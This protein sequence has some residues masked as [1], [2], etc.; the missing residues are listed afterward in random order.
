M[1]VPSW[2]AFVQDYDPSLSVSAGVEGGEG[3]QGQKSMHIALMLCPSI[4]LPHM[5][6]INRFNNSERLVLLCPLSRWGDRLRD[7]KAKIPI[8]FCPT[9]GSMIFS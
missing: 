3:N 5:F 4:V 6:V 2:K 7:G 9:S 1:A 8:E